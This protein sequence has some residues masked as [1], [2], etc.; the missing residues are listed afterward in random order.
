[1]LVVCSDSHDPV[2]WDP[3]ETDECWMCGR[4][5]RVPPD[6]A[7]YSEARGDKDSLA[8]REASDEALVHSRPP[9]VDSA[10]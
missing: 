1:M 3:V 9:A 10:S 5:I 8:D 4:S 6:D 7:R 2:C